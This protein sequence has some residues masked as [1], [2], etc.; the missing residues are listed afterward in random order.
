MKPDIS[1][2]LIVA[3]LVLVGVGLWMVYPPAAVV[4]GGVALAALG[5]HLA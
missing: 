4:F 3:G 2:F 5:I 1:D